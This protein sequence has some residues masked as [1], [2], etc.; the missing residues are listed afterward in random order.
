MSLLA[1]AAGVSPFGPIFGKELRVTSR[2]KRT[3]LLRMGYLGLLL[4]ALLLAYATTGR[5]YG[6]V[7]AQMQRQAALGSAFF[8]A[9]TLFRRAARRFHS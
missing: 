6:G 3:Y 5:S 4:L 2:R 8:A 7:A 1:R 9:F